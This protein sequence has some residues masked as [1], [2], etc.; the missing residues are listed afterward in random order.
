MKDGATTTLFENGGTQSS[1]YSFGASAWD[2]HFSLGGGAKTYLDL[3]FASE[4]S[5]TS[6]TTIPLLSKSV[7]K[8]GGVG[9]QIDNPSVSAVPEPGALAMLA[10]GLGFVGFTMRRRITR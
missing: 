3:Y 10:A 2:A 5:S 9:A 8:I 1:T 7:E 4:F 6:P